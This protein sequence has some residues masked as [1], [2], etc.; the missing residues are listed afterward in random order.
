[1]RFHVNC[2]RLVEF[3]KDLALILVFAISKDLVAADQVADDHLWFTV[4]GTFHYY[5][6]L[7][8]A[9]AADAV[10]DC[11]AQILGG[12]IQ[13]YTAKDTA[14][15]NELPDFV[16][17]DMVGDNHVAKLDTI[18]VANTASNAG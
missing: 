15:S 17:L 7:P 9:N 4:R 5:A 14:S 11:L 12:M 2:D 8:P 16:I 18:A 3:L 1:M 6:I 13:R 10:R